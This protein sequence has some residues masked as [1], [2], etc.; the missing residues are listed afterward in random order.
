MDICVLGAGAIGGYL[1]AKLSLAG[2][3]VSLIT[4]GEQ[5]KAIRE[6]GLT[7]IENGSTNTTF[8]TAYSNALEAG[9]QD[10]LIITL[11]AHSV[12]EVVADINPLLSRKTHV[13]WCVN[14]LPW[15]YFYKCPGKFEN[16]KI[17]TIDPDN[18]QWEKITPERIIGCVVYPAVE[19]E[20]PGKIRHIE[21]NKFSLGELDGSKTERVTK[22]ATEFTNAG[23]RAPIRS[24]IRDELW[25]KLWGNLSFNPISALT[26]ATLAEMCSDSDCYNLIFKMMSE[27]QLVGE[28]IGVN[29]P[30]DIK[31]RIE[32]GKSVGDHKTSMLQ[33]LERGRKMELDALV[34]GIIDLAK[35]TEVPVPNIEAVYEL[36]KLK[37]KI[38][39]CY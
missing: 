31:K 29:F 25:V 38:N 13:I 8:P 27:A 2:S 30:I 11:K 32:G 5:L 24:K 18:R 26:G 36:T 12:I 10:Y 33:D 9:E 19:V 14:G 15:W 28:K 37:A 35:I 17:N 23:L 39:K 22:L 16:T 3:N 4:R 6:D 20:A 21:G 7:L 1:A 34:G